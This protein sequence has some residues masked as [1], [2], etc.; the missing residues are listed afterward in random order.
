MTI[1]LDS[2]L[3]NVIIN[4]SWFDRLI[5]RHKTLTHHNKHHSPLIPTRGSA[6]SNIDKA[7]GAGKE[8]YSYSVAEFV[9]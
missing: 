5:E 6:V 7:K 3:D 9:T 2:F 8:W 4:H 1:L